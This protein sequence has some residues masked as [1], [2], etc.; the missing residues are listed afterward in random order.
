[1]HSCRGPLI[2]YSDLLFL[3]FPSS[4]PATLVNQKKSIL[5]AREGI[6]YS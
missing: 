4:E 2:I 3:L 6:K 5:G 1:M